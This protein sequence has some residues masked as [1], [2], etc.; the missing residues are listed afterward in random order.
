MEKRVTIT[1]TFK[2][3][4]SYH[5]EIINLIVINTLYIHVVIIY[6]SLIALFIHIVLEY[7]RII[8]SVYRS[9]RSEIGLD[10]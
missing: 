9:I 10:F 7:C 1:V 5:L 4:F 6:Y 3:N 8:D 2:R